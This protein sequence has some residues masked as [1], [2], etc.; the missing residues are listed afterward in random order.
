VT[1]QYSN[2]LTGDDQPEY[3]PEYQPEYAPQYVPQYAPEYPPPYQP[4]HTTFEPQGFLPMAPPRR[5]PWGKIIAVLL[6]LAVLGGAAAAVVL[7][8]NNAKHPATGFNN[9][10]VLAA[11]IQIKVQARLDDP[12]GRFYNPNATVTSVNCIAKGAHEFVCLL[13]G[14]AGI[15]ETDTVTVSADGNSYITY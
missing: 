9:P 8:H 3:R 15:A 12:D 7:T 1:F 10:Q 13:T 14:S 4:Q 11:D 5:T 2:P 6:T